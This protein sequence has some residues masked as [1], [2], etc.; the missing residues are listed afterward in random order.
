MTTS[1]IRRL[2]Q[3]KLQ[4]SSGSSSSMSFNIKQLAK[5][6]KAYKARYKLGTAGKSHTEWLMLTTIEV[7][8]TTFPHDDV[9]SIIITDKARKCLEK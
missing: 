1:Q 9:V 7:A 6:I 2:W 5:F 4:M 8:K 3:V